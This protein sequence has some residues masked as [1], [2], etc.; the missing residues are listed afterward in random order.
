VK[1]QGQCDAGYAFCS[2]SLAESIN[3]MKST[4]VLLSEQQV[5][6]CADAYSTFGCQSGSRDGTLRF[7]QEKG[8]TTQ[9]K[10]PYVGVKQN[11]KSTASDFKI[12]QFIVV[13]IGCNELISQL[14]VSPLTVAVNIDNWQLYKSGIFDNCGSTVGHDVYLVGFTA[15]NW[16]VKNSWGVRWGEYGYIRLKMGNTCG[17]CSRPGFGFKL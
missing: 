14:S 9:A 7:L 4:S 1:N 2:V 16:R 12:S 11:C 8:V 10:Y 6:D 5:I 13:A 17:I 15:D 3:L